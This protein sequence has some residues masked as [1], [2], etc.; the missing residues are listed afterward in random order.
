ML[1]LNLGGKRY[2]GSI[3]VFQALGFSNPSYVSLSTGGGAGNP[4]LWPLFVPRHGAR[5][6][7]PEEA[8]MAAKACGNH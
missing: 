8:A 6:T 3:S 7:P 1:R 5:Y 2:G 4:G